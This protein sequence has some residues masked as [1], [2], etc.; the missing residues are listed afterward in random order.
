MDLEIHPAGREGLAASGNTT[1]RTTARSERIEVI[2]RG[3]RRR[4][5]TTEQKREI[6]MESLAP[7]ATAAEVARRHEISTGLLYTWRKQLLNG[8]LGGAPQALPR[9]LRADVPPAARHDQSTEAASSVVEAVNGPAP[10]LSSLPDMSRLEGV[11]EIALP[12]GVC[13]RIGARA[14]VTVLRRVLAILEG[15]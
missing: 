11:I 14:D 6:A 12:S 2:T 5:W 4:S 3:E 1:N 8:E 15:R 9:F 10:Q 13:V 7:G